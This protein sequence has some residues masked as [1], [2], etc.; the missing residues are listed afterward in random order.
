MTGWGKRG[1]KKMRKKG[2]ANLKYHFK[3]KTHQGN[4]A[5]FITPY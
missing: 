4:Y 3:L 1:K 2:T 5:V